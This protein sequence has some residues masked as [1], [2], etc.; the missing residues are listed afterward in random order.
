MRDRQRGSATKRGYGSAWQRLSRAVLEGHRSIYG[1]WCPG[2]RVP[3]H[4]SSDLTVDHVIPKALGGTD[5]RENTQVL[6]RA[7]NGRKRDNRA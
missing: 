2:Y 7:C 1:E 3:A 4:S 6:C 5:T